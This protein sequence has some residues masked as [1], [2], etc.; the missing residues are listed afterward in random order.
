MP[1]L[2][3]TNCQVISPSSLVVR[4]GA[5]YQGMTQCT[6]GGGAAVWPS[7]VHALTT[8]QLLA[9]ARLPACHGTSG[10][11]LRA[12][13]EAHAARPKDAATNRLRVCAVVS[14]IR[15]GMKTKM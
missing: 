15:E 2:S 13:A 12:G 11:E 7:T 14:I 1:A 10:S 4:I 5:G 9:G 3:T 8:P 6:K